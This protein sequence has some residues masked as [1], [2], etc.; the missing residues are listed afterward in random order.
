[1]ALLTE[2]AVCCS[3]VPP[4][5][6][7]A[8][9]ARLV[10]DAN[11]GLKEY[12]ADRQAWIQ[13]K[14]FDELH[15][16]RWLLAILKSENLSH[17]RGSSLVDVG[18]GYGGFSVAAS[19][20]GFSVT[21]LEPHP[22]LANLIALRAKK[23]NQTV[24]VVTVPAESYTPRQRFDIVTLWNVLEHVRDPTAMLQIV[25]GWINRDGRIYLN[26]MNRYSAY[27]PHV[28]LWGVN[29]LPSALRQF[30]S[31]RLRPATGDEAYAM[32]L[33]DLHYFT[34]ASFTSLA[35]KCGLHVRPLEKPRSIR[36]RFRPSFI[37]ECR[38]A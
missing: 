13:D 33:A 35:A 9:I 26:F 1:M 27:D 32:R 21:A 6:I 3:M 20:Y 15:M 36:Q 28:H 10:I 38:A 23:F 16:Q 29:F 2:Q 11:K 7:D 19:M 31:D 12:I 4:E 14:V 18:A 24:E 22:I 30:V 5:S 8:D 25:R 17:A 34:H 37:V